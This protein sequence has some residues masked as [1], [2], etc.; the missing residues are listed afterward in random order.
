MY[1]NTKEHKEA[2]A[3]AKEA[4]KEARQWERE[5]KQILGSIDKQVKEELENIKKQGKESIGDIVKQ[6]Q[7]QMRIS[8]LWSDALR[9]H[10]EDKYE[11]ACD[12]YSKIEPLTGKK[13]VAE[14]YYNWG[15]ALFDLAKIKKDENLFE[16]ARQK[17]EQAIKIK[18]NYYQAYSNYGNALSNRAVLKG[19]EELFKEACGKYA[20]A[21]EI[22]PDEYIPYICWSN[23]L[24]SWAKLKKGTPEYEGLLKQTEEK[25]LKTE[26]LKT[27]KGAYNLA[28][29][30][31]IRE[32]T[33]E[34]KKWLLA[35]QEAN[36]LVTRDKAMK[37]SDLEN[38]RGEAWFKEI[39]WKGE[40]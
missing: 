3:E 23:A 38:V 28:C 20:K 14:L 5:A 29:F 37:D 24:L 22:K 17:Y 15:N 21:V 2:V 4:S 39:K 16:Q 9:L 33:E 25:C 32:N 35:G 40:K 19:N 6:T 8:E 31:A 26:S 13:P 34:C 18:P 12:R 36:E 1:K 10:N 7:T 27:G 30:Y 11:E